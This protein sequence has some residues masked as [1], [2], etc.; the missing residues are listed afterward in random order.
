[1]ISVVWLRH[2]AVSVCMN[3]K[4]T[5]QV[6]SNNTKTATCTCIQLQWNVRNKDTLKLIM[7]TSRGPNGVL[8]EVSLYIHVHSEWCTLSSFSVVDHPIKALRIYRTHI[9]W[10]LLH[11]PCPYHNIEHGVPHRHTIFS[12][13]TP[14]RRVHLCRNGAWGGIDPSSIR[15]RLSCRQRIPLRVCS[16]PSC[17]FSIK[18][19]PL[20]IVVVL[21]DLQTHHSSV[22]GQLQAV[23]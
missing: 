8:S 14:I 7:D 5:V 10:L 20:H 17:Q 22:Q 4:Y 2:N 3:A 13:N 6:C 1:M 15:I 11:C 19:T 21:L 16:W 12:S 9:C 18:V 23:G